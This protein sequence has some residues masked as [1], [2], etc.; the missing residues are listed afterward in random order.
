MN[1]RYLIFFSPEARKQEKQWNTRIRFAHL[2]NINCLNNSLNVVR[3]VK[4]AGKRDRGARF[5]T[6]EISRRTY[7]LSIPHLFFL[8][9]QSNRMLHWKSSCYISFLFRRLS[10]HLRG[11]IRCNSL[12]NPNS[13][14]ITNKYDRYFLRKYW[15]QN[16][17]SFNE[18]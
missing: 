14:Y 10:A 4:S 16:W 7:T 8:P 6:S 1:M 15:N 9:G 17:T 2:S 3:G 13:N 5:Y 18:W 12:R 11:L